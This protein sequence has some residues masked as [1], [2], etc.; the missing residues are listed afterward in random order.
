MDKYVAE[1]K[2]TVTHENAETGKPK[3]AED[4]V[5]KKGI[6]TKTVGKYVATGVA[7]TLTASQMYAKQR[8]ASNNITGDSISQRR[9]DNNMAYLNE[10]LSLL[11]TIGV[12]ALVGGPAGALAGATAV[13]I[14]FGMNAYNTAQD[15]RVKQANWQVESIVNQDK[16]SRLVKDITGVRV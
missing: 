9:M 10:G 12:G 13:A 8:S 7:L 2:T 1:F 16:Q 14:R 15:N 5:N 11:G 4:I 3:Q 6:D